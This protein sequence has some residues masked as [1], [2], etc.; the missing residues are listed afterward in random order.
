[1]ACSPRSSGGPVKWVETRSE[2]MAST[3]HGRDQIDY[4][5]MGA[6]RDGTITGSTQR[7]RGPRRVPPA[8]HAVHPVVQGVRDGRRATR[9]RRVQTDIIGVFTNKFP[10]DAIRGAGRPRRPT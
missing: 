10:T 4:V 9:S 1:M 2:D 6:K 3:H 7:D 5:K 8:A